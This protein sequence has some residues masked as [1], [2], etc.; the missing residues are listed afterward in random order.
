M[1]IL[2]I[3]DNLQVQKLLSRIIEP[4]GT[5]E[6]A[7]DGKIGQQLFKEAHNENDP[8]DLIV[9]DIMMPEMNGDELLGHIRQWEKENISITQKVKIIILSA[10]GNP[11]KM[12]TCFEDGCDYYLVKP[13]IKSDL[14]DILEKVKEWLQ[15]MSE[16][17]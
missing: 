2:V 17:S 5:V 10:I 14:I 15:L 9:L 12:L 13:I 6:I 3:D 8:F 1:K 16:E 11:K 4:Y 7:G